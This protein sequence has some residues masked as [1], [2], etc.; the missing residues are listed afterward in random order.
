[1]DPSRHKEL[2][3]VSNTTI[4][5]NAKN[6][7]DEGIPLIIRIPVIPS[8]NDNI[9]NIN[10]TIEFT[11]HN[12]RNTTGIEFMHYHTMGKEKYTSLG[13][14]YDLGHIDTLNEEDVNSLE[15]LISCSDQ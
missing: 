11:R 14:S 9:E 1:M 15:R 12:L 10:A 5:Q 7:S 13:L 2:T 6:I 3:G 4:L 8:L